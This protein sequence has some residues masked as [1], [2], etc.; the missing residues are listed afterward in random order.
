MCHISYQ[1]AI[2]IA[3]TNILF[4]QP[5]DFS[6]KV[7]V[8][9]LRVIVTAQ[10][11]ADGVVQGTLGRTVPYGWMDVRFPLRFRGLQVSSRRLV[12]GLAHGETTHFGVRLGG[13][14]KTSDGGGLG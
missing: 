12:L 2:K 11:R 9:K 5:A 1:I 6:L 3:K 10:I 14:L 7:I 8:F 4:P 13:D